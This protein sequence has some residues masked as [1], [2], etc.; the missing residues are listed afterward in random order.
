MILEDAG[1]VDVPEL[2]GDE[3]GK[4]DEDLSSGPEQE[5]PSRFSPERVEEIKAAFALNYSGI[6]IGRPEDM[7]RLQGYNARE[8]SNKEIASVSHLDIA[9]RVKIYLRIPRVPRNYYTPRMR[10]LKFKKSRQPYYMMKDLPVEVTVFTQRNK[11]EPTHFIKGNMKIMDEHR[12]S[13][14]QS[15]TI[16]VMLSDTLREEIRK[17]GFTFSGTTKITLNLEVLKKAGGNRN[18]IKI[19]ENN[20]VDRTLAKIQALISDEGATATTETDSSAVTVDTPSEVTTAST[21]TAT[22][23]GTGTKSTQEQHI[24][25]LETI[26]NTR[27][28]PE[29]IKAGLLR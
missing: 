4:E 23:T 5:I 19:Y 7:K 24:L 13:A 14:D 9:D 2:P 21:D 27:Q 3:E 15:Q 29:D 18:G 28:R 8:R 17:L 11:R 20:V 10:N 22:S 26:K 16:D 25:G 6:W 12:D 1:S